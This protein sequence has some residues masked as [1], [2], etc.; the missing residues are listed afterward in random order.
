MALAV[1][2]YGAFVIVVMYVPH[3]QFLPTKDYP[4]F[5]DAL[6]SL[7]KEEQLVAQKPM[8]AA[9][10]CAGPVSKGRCE[11]TNLG[12]TI[13]AAEVQAVYGIKYDVALSLF[14]SRE[15]LLFVV[16]MLC[17]TSIDRGCP[18]KCYRNV[19][20]YMYIVSNP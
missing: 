13:D 20:M 18:E 1:S 2:T 16:I 10:A 17:Q 9:F 6:G 3:L 12:W 7:L 11:M 4:T 14:Y 15:R 8:S 5:M 19:V